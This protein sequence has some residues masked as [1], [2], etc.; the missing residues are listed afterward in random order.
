MLS[1]FIF[2]EIMVVLFPPQNSLNHFSIFFLLD[3]SINYF[4]KQCD[5]VCMYREMGMN[6]VTWLLVK[7][8]KI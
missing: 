5:S 4:Y 8:L 7:T 1:C 3:N 2:V 6:V